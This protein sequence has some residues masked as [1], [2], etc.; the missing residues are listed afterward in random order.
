MLLRCSRQA[1]TGIL[2]CKT[3]FSLSLCTVFLCLSMHSH[4]IKR[5][6]AHIVLELHT[7]PVYSNSSLLV[8][9]S[10]RYNFKPS[11]LPLVFM[12]TSRQSGPF[13]DGQSISHELKWVLRRPYFHR[14][15]V[16]EVGDVIKVVE[17]I[18]E[19]IEQV[20]GGFAIT[21]DA[22]VGSVQLPQALITALWLVP[23]S[24]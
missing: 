4:S 3:I 11:A 2:W 8:D 14:A 17:V 18:E 15:Q 12:W 22:E 1:S 16:P 10:R 20:A 24:L 19:A 7:T 6:Q 5:Y 21:C 23:A 13:R 9:D